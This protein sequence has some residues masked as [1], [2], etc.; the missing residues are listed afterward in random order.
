MTNPYLGE[1]RMFAGNFAPKNNA[2][3]WGQIISIQQNSALFSLYGT[4]YGG[5][6]TTTFGLPD[7]RGRLAVG[8]GQGPGLQN[9][10]MGEQQGTEAVT[11]TTQQMPMHNHPPTATTVGTANVNTPQGNYPATL[12]NPPW[13]G[14]WIANGKQTGSPIQFSASAVGFTGNNLPHENR[15][16]AMALTYIVALSGIFP[17]RN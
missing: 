5:N 16:P 8:Q 17:S 6:G 2:M 1:V 3:A 13:T 15:M 9:W 4:Y 12:A 11:L 14:Y 10:T 7:L